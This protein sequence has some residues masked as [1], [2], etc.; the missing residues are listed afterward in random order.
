MRHTQ[1]IPKEA[2]SIRRRIYKVAMRTQLVIRLWAADCMPR[3]R[4]VPGSM[5]HIHRGLPR[6]TRHRRR[7]RNTLGKMRPPHHTNE[8]TRSSSIQTKRVRPIKQHPTSKRTSMLYLVVPVSE[9]PLKTGSELDVELRVGRSE[10]GDL[11]AYHAENGTG[12]ARKNILVQMFDSVE[13]M[14]TELV[15][16]SASVLTVRWR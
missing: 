1:H 9:G 16:K 6:R 13:T 3:S 4:N 2:R 5:G 7:T 15:T 14:R 12:Y 10:H 8:R 11:R